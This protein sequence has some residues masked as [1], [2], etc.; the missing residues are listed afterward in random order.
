[1]IIFDLDQTL[2]DT[3]PVENLRQA[4]KWSAVMQRVPNL[5]VFEGISPLIAELHAAGETMAIVTK[6]P[7]MVA[8]AFVAQ[9]GWPIEIIIGY[10]QVSYRK[11][12]PE[13][14]LRALERAGATAA[15][16]FH[17]GD[18]P[19]DTLASDAAGMRALGAAWGI[20]DATDLHSSNPEEVFDTVS[21]LHEFLTSIRQIT[22]RR[23]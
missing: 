14:L 4:R 11:P 16:S 21:G 23:A 1:M 7:D 9:H 13:G 10:H 5:P 17:I 6:S 20:E 18:R 22:P 2:V 12:H 19:E 3:R 15:D 8:K